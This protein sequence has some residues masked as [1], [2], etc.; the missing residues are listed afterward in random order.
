VLIAGQGNYKL[1]TTHSTHSELRDPFLT[2]A[3]A[4]LE[5]E[6]VDICAP[7]DTGVDKMRNMLVRLQLGHTRK[8]LGASV[9]CCSG[10]TN[11]VALVCLGKENSRA[12][13]R[14]AILGVSCLYQ[15]C[16]VL[17]LHHFICIFICFNTFASTHGLCHACRLASVRSSTFHSN[18]WRSHR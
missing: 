4:A 2:Q 11:W 5:L 8:L 10:D 1:I 12:T 6:L 3:L 9:F 18:K 13:T 7:D 17:V 15:L 14:A 16:F